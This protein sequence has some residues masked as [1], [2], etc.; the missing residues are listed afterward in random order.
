M[1][2]LLQLRRNRLRILLGD[3]DKLYRPLGRDILFS[4][5]LTWL[6]LHIAKGTV[7]YFPRQARLQPHF[8]SL[9]AIGASIRGRV[10]SLERSS[11]AKHLH[12]SISIKTRPTVAQSVSCV[13]NGFRGLAE[14]VGWTTNRDRKSR[15]TLDGLLLMV[16]WG[17]LGAV[18]D[19][20]RSQKRGSSGRGSWRTSRIFRSFNRSPRNRGKIRELN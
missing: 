14:D 15:G 1:I 2:V 3:T 7:T 20:P 11:A 13:L 16:R 19:R 8:H 9:V 6:N 12:S 17:R 4:K 5:W 10:R 18:D